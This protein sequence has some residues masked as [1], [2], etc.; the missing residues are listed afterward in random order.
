[1]WVQIF[2][3]SATPG[4]F[5]VRAFKTRAAR[6][7]RR[8]I[9]HIFSCCVGAFRSSNRTDENF[10]RGCCALRSRMSPVR[11][12]RFLVLGL[13]VVSGS[14]SNQAFSRLEKIGE[15]LAERLAVAQGLWHC[16]D[17]SFFFQLSFAS[18]R[19][20]PNLSKMSFAT[21]VILLRACREYWQPFVLRRDVSALEGS[22]SIAM[23]L[24]K[25]KL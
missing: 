4:R 23:G 10:G 16:F 21:A 7:P 11:I 1:M 24:S 6:C 12:G 2:A 14:Q 5:F 18:W 15:W 22:A 9:C 25:C 3:T 20:C 8:T 17:L 13:R 19:C